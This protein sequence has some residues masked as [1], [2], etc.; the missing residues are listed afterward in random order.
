M[1]NFDFLRN[2]TVIIIQSLGNFSFSSKVYKNRL[3][4][5]L[6]FFI[7]I[8]KSKAFLSIEK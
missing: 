4:I 1:V 5:E 7:K 6:N 2:Q 8:N 3:D